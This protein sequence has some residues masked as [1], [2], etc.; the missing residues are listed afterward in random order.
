V[1]SPRCV[2]A[3]GVGRHGARSG[4]GA[5]SGVGGCDCHGAK[6]VDGRTKLAAHDGGAVERGGCAASAGVEVAGGDKRGGLVVVEALGQTVG[7]CFSL[8]GVVKVEL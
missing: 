4:K 1:D 3:V 6:R 2:V 8:C 7:P 5:V